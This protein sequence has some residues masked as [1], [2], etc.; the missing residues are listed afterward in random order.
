METK[1][2]CRLTAP[3]AASIA[4]L[5]GGLRLL[6]QRTPI[7]AISFLFCPKKPALGE[8]FIPERFSK[9]QKTIRQSRGV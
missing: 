2:I 6:A 5:D 8:S 4:L 1:K 9:L 7:A 3:S